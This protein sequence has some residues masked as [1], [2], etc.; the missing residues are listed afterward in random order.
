LQWGARGAD[1]SIGICNSMDAEGPAD[2]YM[3]SE[4]EGA[5]DSAAG[6]YI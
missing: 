3:Q 5:A 1:G 6:T 4:L 2:A